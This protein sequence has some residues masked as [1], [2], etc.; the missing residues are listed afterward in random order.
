MMVG[1][2]TISQFL[3]LCLLAAGTAIILLGRKTGNKKEQKTEGN[4]NDRS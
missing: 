4:G 3:S 2:L 1:P